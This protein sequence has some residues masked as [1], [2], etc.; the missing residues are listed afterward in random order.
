M[1]LKIGEII[2]YGKGQQPIKVNIFD[3]C[4]IEIRA[5][6]ENSSTKVYKR[7][8]N[9]FIKNIHFMNQFVDS[10]EVSNKMKDWRK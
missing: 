9:K 2:L 1:L 3:G 8:G 10:N 4:E 5:V 6:S 7:E